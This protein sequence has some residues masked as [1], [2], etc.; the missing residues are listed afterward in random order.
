MSTETMSA[1]AKAVNFATDPHLDS[2]VKQFLKLLNGGG[3]PPL[4]SMSPID[5]RK[6][7]VDAQASV[8]VDLSGIDIEE[9]IIITDGYTINLHIVRPEKV[10]EILP[11]FIF[12]HGGG[13]VLG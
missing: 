4:E 1:P 7:L 12:I 6:V 8:K 2:H 13:W 5:A 10:K 3:G 11:V 9:K